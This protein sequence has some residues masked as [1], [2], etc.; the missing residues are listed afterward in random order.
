LVKVDGAV[1]GL[2]SWIFYFIEFHRCIGN[3]LLCEIMYNTQ[4]M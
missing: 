4:I 3:Y 2:W 1:S